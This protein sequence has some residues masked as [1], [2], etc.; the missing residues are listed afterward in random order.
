VKRSRIIVISSVLAAALGA[1]TGFLG[2]R[3]MGPAAP[4]P[5]EMH[6]YR[7]LGSNVDPNAE[8]PK[9]WNVPAFALS[10]QH[11]ATTTNQALRGQVWIADFV[12]T[13]C[14]SACPILT[15]RLVKLQRQLT[16]K[17]LRFVSFS[18]DPKHDT[19]AALL[20]YAETWNPPESR[21]W[22]FSTTESSL[23]ELARDM[24]VAVEAKPD[25][26]DPILHSNMFFLVDADGVV[27]GIY[28]SNDDAALARLKF[29]AGRLLGSPAPAPEIPSTGAEL[30]ARLNCAACHDNAALAPSLSGVL[31]RSV[32]LADG[33]KIVADRVYLQ[34]SIT[35]PGAQLVAGFLNLMPS[36]RQELSDAQLSQLVEHVASLAPAD[37]SAPGDLSAR[38]GSAAPAEGAA[39]GASKSAIGTV[40][41]DPVCQMDVRVTEATPRAEHAGRVYHFCSESCRTQFASAPAQFVPK[42]Q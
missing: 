12:Y 37:P 14:T 36:Y 16:H 10:N 15:S 32:Q 20:A 33:A 42:V 4:A 26:A 8:L 11:G 25:V 23:K 2:S 19:P 5:A 13:T 9:L 17:A 27:R 7:T 40:V 1:L 29:D 30:Y 18:V 21:W 41:V 35:A 39:S 22:L 38:P 3:L 24:R 31:G 6:A 28:D 34:Q